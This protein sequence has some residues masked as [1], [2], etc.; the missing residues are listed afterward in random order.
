VAD[1]L[2]RLHFETGHWRADFLIDRTTGSGRVQP[3][4]CRHPVSADQRIADRGTAGRD[5]SKWVERVKSMH[6][7]RHASLPPSQI[8]PAWPPRNGRSMSPGPLRSRSGRSR[9]TRLEKLNGRPGR[10]DREE[11]VRREPSLFAF[12]HQGTVERG[13]SNVGK[14]AGTSR[15]LNAADRLDPTHCCRWQT[16]HEGQQCGPLQSSDLR[17]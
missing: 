15:S 12:G 5:R 10:G 4:G 11:V 8:W 2:W 17:I 1:D 9:T 16:R 6:P 3:T 13:S 14:P 7:F